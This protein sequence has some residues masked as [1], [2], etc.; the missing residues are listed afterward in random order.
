MAQEALRKQPRLKLSLDKTAESGAG[1]HLLPPGCADAEPAACSLRGPIINSTFAEFKAP[2][3]THGGL[4]NEGHNEDND[5]RARVEEPST[6]LEARSAK[7]ALAHPTP[8]RLRSAPWA[9]SSV[10]MSWGRGGGGGWLEGTLVT[11]AAARD[12]FSLEAAAP[13]ALQTASGSGYI[14]AL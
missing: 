8:P 12:M 2:G 3:K 13:K 7:V 1:V 9:S 4:E 14:S 5:E 6:Y 11:C 10:R